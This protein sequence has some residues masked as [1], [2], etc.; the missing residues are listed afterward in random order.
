MSSGGRLTVEA[1]IMPRNQKEVAMVVLNIVDPKNAEKLANSKKQLADMKRRDRM[2]SATART[3]AA[4]IKA[5]RR[6]SMKRGR[7]IWQ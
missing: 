7:H 2:N 5:N 4:A 3:V 1:A 6:G